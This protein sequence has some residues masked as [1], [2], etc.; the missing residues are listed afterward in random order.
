VAN[1]RNF[2]PH[3]PKLRLHLQGKGTQHRQMAV[4][5]LL[6]PGGRRAASAHWC[7]GRAAERCH[8]GSRHCRAG[9]EHCLTQLPRSC[10]PACCWLGN[11]EGLGGKKGL[12]LQNSPAQICVWQQK[13]LCQDKSSSNLIKIMQI[14]NPDWSSKKHSLHLLLISSVKHIT[15]RR[16]A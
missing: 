15:L 7:A 5:C 4:P 8:A 10:S 9:C 1:Q 16:G 14:I 11:A 3:V 6:L 2:I 13:H 12:R